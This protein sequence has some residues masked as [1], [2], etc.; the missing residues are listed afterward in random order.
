MHARA[1]IGMADYT[2]DVPDD[3]QDRADELTAETVLSK[4][5]A[6]VRA[7]SEAGLPRQDIAD[8]LGISINT[9]DEHR[10][11]IKERLRLAENTVEEIGNG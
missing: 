6:D 8:E 7:L 1:P 4:R 2:A 9:V 5:Q 3:W 11:G 10:Q